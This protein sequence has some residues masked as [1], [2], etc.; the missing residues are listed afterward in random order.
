MVAN[1]KL[2]WNKVNQY[3]S[4]LQ[5]KS[6]DDIKRARE[7]FELGKTMCPEALTGVFISNYMKSDGK[8]QSK[9]IWFFSDN[10]VI[11]AL[12]F[13]KIK[14]PKLEI[15]THAKNLYYITIE[16][17]NYKFGQKTQEDSLLR[18]AFLT[19]SR[20]EC[21][22]KATGQNCNNLCRIFEQFIKN[23]IARAGRIVASDDVF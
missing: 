9:D 15:T 2:F 19:V 12:N 8:E 16:S 1:N 22:F 23:N 6:V 7:V 18:I 10:F 13:I 14:N 11:E 3:L 21:D 5:I 4:D 17:Q 20:F